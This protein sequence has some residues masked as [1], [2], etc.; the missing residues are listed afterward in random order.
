MNKKLIALLLA[1]APSAQADEGW[2]ALFDGKTLDGW[3][4]KSGF[5]TYRVEDGAILG[6]TAEG[7]G[8]T[9]LC[10][11]EQFADFELVFEVKLDNNELNSGVQLRSQLR[12]APY[13]GRV[14]G[15]QVEIAAGSAS[16]Y[17]YGEGLGHWLSPEPRAKHAQFKNGAWNKFRVRAVGTRIQTWINDQPIADLTLAA[18]DAKNYPKG[19]I[20]LQVHGIGKKPGGPFQVRW[21]N[22][23]LRP[24]A[25]ETKK[26]K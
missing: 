24:V 18:D 8:N 10:T 22:L 17:V 16:G 9:F 14:H 26:E 4:V 13:G 23:Q 25:P 11:K 3:E 5:A 1:I 12:E 21:R 2:R 7:S 6:K 19:L 15:P 20:G